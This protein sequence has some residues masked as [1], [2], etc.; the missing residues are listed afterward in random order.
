MRSFFGPKAVTSN[1]EVAQQADT[2]LDQRANNPT[3]D[4]IGTTS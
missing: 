2:S 3:V 4:I 1:L